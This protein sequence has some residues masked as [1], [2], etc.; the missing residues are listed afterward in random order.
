MLTLSMLVALPILW[1]GERQVLLGRQRDREPHHF[2]RGRLLLEVYEGLYCG[3]RG[4]IGLRKLQGEAGLGGSGAVLD[5]F[6]APKEPGV[7]RSIRSEERRAWKVLT[8]SLPQD[9]QEYI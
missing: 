5:P 1:S 4:S 2:R 9:T 6:A 3:D 7:R 8:F